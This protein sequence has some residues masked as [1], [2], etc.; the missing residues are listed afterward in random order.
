MTPLQL[1]QQQRFLQQQQNSGQ[2]TP[3]NQF[4]FS[5]PSPLSGTTPFAQG[6][7]GGSNQF[8]NNLQS[9]GN[10]LP[11]Q[12]NLTQQQQQNRQQQLNNQQHSQNDQQQQQLST[13][14]LRARPNQLVNTFGYNPYRR[15][16]KSAAKVVKP[17]EH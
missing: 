12:Q 6:A 10:F 17:E 7:A 8:G 4:G 5:P 11:Q 16:K 15:Y 2:Y 13:Q 1:Q 14:E 3:D 9:Q